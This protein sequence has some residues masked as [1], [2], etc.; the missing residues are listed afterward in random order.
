MENQA[1]IILT[2]FYGFMG[3]ML[4]TVTII[5]FF[6]RSQRQKHLKK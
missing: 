4:L 5:Y 1:T 3:L 2:M 6:D